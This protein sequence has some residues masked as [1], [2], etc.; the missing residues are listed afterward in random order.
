M[1]NSLLAF[2]L[3]IFI[4]DAP[5]RFTAAY[6]YPISPSAGMLI[7]LTEFL[8]IPAIYLFVKSSIFQVFT[9]RERRR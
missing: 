4:Q 9:I 7:S 1:P 5:S 2:F 8:Y 3:L 6:I